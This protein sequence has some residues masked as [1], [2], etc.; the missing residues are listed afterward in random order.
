MVTIAP[1]LS[2]SID[3]IKECDAVVTI[4]HTDCNY[5]EA[6]LAMEAGANCL[7]H[8]FNAMTP[9]HHRMPG[10][11][12]CSLNSKEA[13]TEIIC[14]GIHLHPAIVQLTYNA[15]SKDKLVLI[16][17]SMCAT[18]MADGEYGIAGTKVFVKN[19][20]GSA[21]FSNTKRQH[22]WPVDLNRDDRIDFVGINVN[23]NSCTSLQSK[24]FN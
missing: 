5:E 12:V 22:I 11:A 18:A 16:T 19:G 8:T 14:D 24:Y 13:Y 7:T 20:Y 23:G 17:D 3:F 2:G 6:V 4:G 9:V 10:A 21:W 15:K 1:E